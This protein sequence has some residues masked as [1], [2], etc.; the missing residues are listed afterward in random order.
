MAF[1]APAEIVQQM[2]DDFQQITGIQLSPNDFDNEIVIK[3]WTY[4]GAISSMYSA[5][6]KTRD[7]IWPGSASEDGLR[8]HLAAHQL[9]PQIQPQPSNGVLLFTGT[10]NTVVPI[11]TQVKRRLDGKVFL[12]TAAATIPALGTTVSVPF[13]SLVSGQASNVDQ[14]GDAYDLVQPIAGITGIV[15]TSSFRDGRDLETAAEMLARIEASEQD[16]NTGG[17]LVAYQAMA[18]AASGDVVTATAIKN[19]RGVGTVNTV[20]TSGT[21]DIAG[22][23]NSGQAV[24]RLPSTA[25]INAVQAYILANNPTTDDHLTVAPTEAAFNVTYTYALFDESLRAL[26]NAQV[27]KIIQIF[28]YSAVPNEILYPTDLERQIDQALGHL[29]KSRRVS[30]FGGGGPSFTVPAA[31]ILTP[32]TITLAGP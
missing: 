27:T 6:E 26:V 3:C 17:N 10:Q 30:D 8:R 5:N 32:G 11:G 4:A 7:D 28:V 1:K 29:I 14:I 9:P 15:S 23:V 13:Q 22:A 31:Q 2:L 20:I 18:K 16:V 24:S 25:L 21:T 19:A 12:S